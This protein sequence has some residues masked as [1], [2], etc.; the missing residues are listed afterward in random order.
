MLFCFEF[1]T[2]ILRRKN[3]AKED[4]SVFNSALESGPPTRQI[5]RRGTDLLSA[6]RVLT[7]KL[8]RKPYLL[9]WVQTVAS[10]RQVCAM[11]QCFHEW[12]ERIFLSWIWILRFI[13]VWLCDL[14]FVTTIFQHESTKRAT[15]ANLVRH[16]HQSGKN[17]HLDIRCW[18]W[19]YFFFIIFLP[20]IIL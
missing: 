6:H 17:C 20:S 10:L 19:H 12:F 4:K 15:A 18:G 8:R 13:F 9:S 16:F 1:L 2:Q 3:W 14:F 11:Q 7:E 5:K